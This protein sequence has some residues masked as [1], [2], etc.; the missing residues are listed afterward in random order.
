M[1]KIAIVALLLTLG[2]GA[3]AQKS[4]PNTVTIIGTVSGDTKGFQKIYFYSRSRTKDSVAIK[5][6][7]FTVVLP[8]QKPDME[9]FYTEYD[10]KQ[11]GMYSPFALLVDRP[12]VIYLKD[13][14]L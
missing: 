7:K 12:G 2:S 9:L 14:D 3:G 11:K 5:D 8:Y 13:L 4:K 1:K 10:V 6:G